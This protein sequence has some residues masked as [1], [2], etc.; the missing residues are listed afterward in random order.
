MYLLK[1]PGKPSEIPI[2]YNLYATNLKSK[3]KNLDDLL[4]RRSQAFGWTD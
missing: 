4:N 2:I 1:Q 3:P